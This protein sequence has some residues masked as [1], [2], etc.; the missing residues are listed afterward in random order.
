M[1]NAVFK[2]VRAIRHK[3]KKQLITINDRL[4]S[5]AWELSSAND[6]LNDPNVDKAIRTIDEALE[7]LQVATAML[8]TVMM[9]E[10]LAAELEEAP[11]AAPRPKRSLMPKKGAMPKV[12]LGSS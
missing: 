3:G 8:N 11:K 1:A 6:G 5:L 9:D 7:S 10:S 2:K 4:N 12:N